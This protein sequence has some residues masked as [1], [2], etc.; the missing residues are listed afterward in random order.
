MCLAWGMGTNE[1]ALFLQERLMT[2]KGNIYITDPSYI[3]QRED[4]MEGFDPL[5][6]SVD[7]S[8]F[9]NSIIRSTGIGDGSWKVYEP[10]SLPNPSYSSI[11]ALIDKSDYKD[12]HVIGE[13]C[14]DS[15]SACVVYQH[16]ADTY[17]PLF[18]AKFKDKSHC[19]TLIKNYDGEIESYY[20]SDGE[21]HFIGIGNRCFYT[22]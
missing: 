3:A 7:S 10:T 5:M 14:V 4:W 11:C 12:C 9:S 19:W 17:N 21:L 2:F 8:E 15:A 20:D 1:Y 6:E 18:M 16:E 13:F 22:A